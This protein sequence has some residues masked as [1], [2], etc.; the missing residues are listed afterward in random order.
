MP[1]ARIIDPQQLA[2]SRELQ[3]PTCAV[4][5]AD[6]S[7]QRRLSHCE[8]SSH[9]PVPTD[10]CVSFSPFRQWRRISATDS[11][12]RRGAP[13]SL[14]PPFRRLR[15]IQPR[16]Q[17]ADAVAAST[18]S[19]NG[20]AGTSVIPW[21]QP[22]RVLCGT[23]GRS[24]LM[25][26]TPGRRHAWRS[27]QHQDLESSRLASCREPVRCQAVAVAPDLEPSINVEHPVR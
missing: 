1:L 15:S 16:R 6:A 3:R 8:M 5:Q 2:A 26:A 22:D 10:E 14:L 4:W 24:M 19:A 23:T 21:S 12:H 27:G 9:P 25:I 20:G 11:A 17:D 13:G 18:W 7:G